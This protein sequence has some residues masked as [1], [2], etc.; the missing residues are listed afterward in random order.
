MSLHP[1]TRD[2]IPTLADLFGRSFRYDTSKLVERLSGDTH[3]YPFSNTYILEDGERG[4]VAGMAMFERPVSLTGTEL[5]ASLIATVSVPPEQRRRG[6]ANRML[7]AGL[8]TARA[9]G[10]PLS[11]LFPYSIPFY[12][13]L[14]YGIVQNAWQM[15]FPLTEMVDFDDA[16]LARRMMPDDLP[17]MKRLYERMRLVHNGWLGRTDWEWRERLLDSSSLAE[18]PHRSEGVVVPSDHGE[19]RGY[20]TFKLAPIKPGAKE[21][22][23]SVQ[24]WVHEDDE[25]WRALAGFVAAQRAQADF[26][27]YVAPEGFP[28][29]HTL[30]ERHTFRNRRETQFVFRDT[31]SVGAGMMGRIVHLE[32]ALTQRHYPEAVRGACI[33][34]ARD[35]QLPA[36]EAPLHFRVENGRASVEAAQQS[37]TATADI[38][39]WSEMYAAALSPREARL[40][41][42][43]D[44][45]D[46]TVAFLTAAFESGP[47]FIHQTDWF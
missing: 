43:L 3:R 4:A 5:Q 12:N 20:L 47:W 22:A 31:V 16:R 36:N 46:A 32:A 30:R 41:A 35:G 34:Q 26:L 15:E 17:A 7:T 10:N 37:P 27:R 33:I 44:A 21:R 19:L 8:E 38:R 42:R 13:R 18:W 14:G 25:S 2:E 9:R 11:L 6:Y 45:D 28:L 24:E 40:L 29:A 23:F 39:T 1:I